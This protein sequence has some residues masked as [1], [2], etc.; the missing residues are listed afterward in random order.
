[1]SDFPN[2]LDFLNFFDFLR[3]YP[4]AYIVLL[5]ATAIFIVR[6]W[7]W[8]LLA[9]TVQYLTVGLL[10]V[11]LLEPRIAFGNVLVGLFIC[12]ILYITAFQVNWGELPEDVTEEEAI[13]L[14]QERIIRFGPYILPT[15]TPF[16]IFFA[17][18]IVLSV[19]ALSQRP[20]F[21]LPAVP[22][23]IE[24]AVYALVGLGLV[25]MSLTSEPLMGG[26]GFLRFLVGF[27]MFYSALEQSLAMTT[28]FSVAN[29]TVALVISYLTQARHAFT[30]ILD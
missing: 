11:D 30:A 17:L 23:H 14:R 26:L 25:N 10:L 3:G 5:T 16:R 6:D 20:T 7:R 8:S 24:L 1:M 22:E 29:L 28:L 12:L 13:Q 18:M 27:F 21:N 4:A 15:D 9:L 2:I 19:V